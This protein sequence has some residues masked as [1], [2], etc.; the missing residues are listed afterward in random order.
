MA[1]VGIRQGSGF[2]YFRPERS[3]DS[4]LLVSG[5]YYMTQN[6][7]AELH[8]MASSGHYPMDETP[9]QRATVI[10]RFP[11]GAVIPSN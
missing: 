11:S 10:E 2:G 9:V 7:N 3:G 5:W 8:M 4:V 1:P 6:P